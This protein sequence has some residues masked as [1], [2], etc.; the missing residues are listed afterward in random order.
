M[1]TSPSPEPPVRSTP[2]AD[3]AAATVAAV[4]EPVWWGAHVREFRWQ[5][6]LARLLADPVW[7]GVG[8]PRGDGSP[9]PAHP[10]LPGG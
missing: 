6:E 5:A 4:V 10:G 9:G 1:S 8:V 2:V 7:R 3:A